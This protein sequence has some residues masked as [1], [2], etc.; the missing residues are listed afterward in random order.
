MIPSKNT[1]QGN[2]FSSE[3]AT[4]LETMI[5]RNGHIV[6][7]TLVERRGN[8]TCGSIESIISITQY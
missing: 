4:L 1:H 8:T 5:L 2:T 3:F 7:S 6:S